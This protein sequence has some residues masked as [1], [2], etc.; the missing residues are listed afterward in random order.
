MNML[1]AVYSGGSDGLKTLRFNLR[2]SSMLI[3]QRIQWV[4]TDVGP[5]LTDGKRRKYFMIRVHS[6]AAQEVSEIAFEEVLTSVI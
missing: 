4:K 3:L 2:L 1:I 5:Q 6:S